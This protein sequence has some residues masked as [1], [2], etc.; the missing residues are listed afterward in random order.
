M[1][2]F[3]KNDK[4]VVVCGPGRTKQSFKDKVNI[5]K[6]VKKHRKNAM[7]GRVSQVPFYGDVSGYTGL[8]DAMNKVDN[9]RK[10]FANMSAEIRKKF[11]NDPIKMIDFLN[12]G[13]NYDEAVKLKMVVPNAEYE[14]LHGKK[15]E[16]NTGNEPPK[17]ES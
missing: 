1:G 2:M 7:F 10:L 14:A 4:P 5:N 3:T 11:D 12:D 15:G 8:Q 6:I 13:K 17:V 9:A 16:Q